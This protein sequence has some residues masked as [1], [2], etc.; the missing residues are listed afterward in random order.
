MCL[1]FSPSSI[2]DFVD[3]LGLFEGVLFFVGPLF[4]FEAF[5]S[6]LCILLVYF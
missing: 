6:V 1:V 2:V 3:W 5:L 4:F